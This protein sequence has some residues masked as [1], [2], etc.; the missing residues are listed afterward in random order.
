MHHF[1]SAPDAWHTKALPQRYVDMNRMPKD[2]IDPKA[3][4]RVLPPLIKGY[5]RA[6][7]YIGEGAVID[8][9]FGTTDV[10]IVLPIQEMKARYRAH[11]V[12]PDEKA[13]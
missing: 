3:A 7:A 11:F 5:L 1:A 8:Y 2:A 9:Q 12:T 6:G 13:A 4:Q 10:L